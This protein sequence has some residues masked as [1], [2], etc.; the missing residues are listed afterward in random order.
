MK[1]S[2]HKS[3]RKR[4]KSSSGKTVEVVHGFRIRET[5][6]GYFL[7]QIRR[8]GLNHTETFNS[9]DAARL[10][11]EQL[12][13]ERTQHGLDA[14]SMTAK[15][16]EEAKSA[17]TVLGGRARL[18]EVVAFWLSHHPDGGAITVQELVEHYL[19]DMVRRK[20][21]P[22]T[23][24]DA[25]RRLNRFCIEHGSFPVGA[26]TSNDVSM[27]LS[28]RGGGSINSN[29]YRKQIRAAFGFALKRGYIQTN[30][31]AAVDPAPV[32]HTTPVHWPVSRV[33]DLLRAAQSFKPDMVP[34]Y[35]IMA[36]AG[37]RPDEAANLNWRNINVGERVIRVLPET[38]KIRS[39]R[40]VNIPDNLAKWLAPWR[41]DSGP[42]APAPV[43]I[44]RWRARLSAAAMLGIEEST[45]R[46]SK[47]KGKKGTAI[48]A[49]RLGWSAIIEDAKKLGDLWHPDV[50]RHSYATY[51]LA[52]YS[53]IGELSEQMGNSPKVIKSSY[54][55]LATAKEATAYWKLE[56]EPK[57]KIIRIEAA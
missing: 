55:G 9:I 49:E 4:K 37:L 35:A 24:G 48:K 33:K 19:A 3:I 52:A 46:R 34:L 17:M 8:Q 36:F 23:L 14:F 41:K 31:V 28:V 21:R 57:G 47:H 7:L 50:L 26:V 54:K 2:A 56:P 25:R 27:W 44:T 5:R 15:D 22:H 11:C 53:D 16:R 32:D 10:K 30:P 13:R 18:S 45:K 40:V 12:H 43:T 42:V 51:W 39:A 29:N 6:P 38:S 20:V 1:S